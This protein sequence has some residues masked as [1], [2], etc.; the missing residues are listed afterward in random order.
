MKQIDTEALLMPENYEEYE[1]KELSITYKTGFGRK[2]TV[3]EFLDALRP[4]LKVKKYTKEEI[5]VL[6]QKMKEEGKL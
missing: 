6:E 5:A 1:G 3:G 2:T 4:P